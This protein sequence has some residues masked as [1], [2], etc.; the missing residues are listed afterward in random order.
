LG[1][2]H[3]SILPFLDQ[4]LDSGKRGFIQFI[5]DVGYSSTPFADEKSFTNINSHDDLKK[6]EQN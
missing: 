1:L 4:F 2:I 6:Y 5:K 3:Q